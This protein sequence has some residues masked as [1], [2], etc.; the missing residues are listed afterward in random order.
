MIIFKRIEIIVRKYIPKFWT[1][2][3]IVR[4]D[5]IISIFK[6]GI[7]DNSIEDMTIGFWTKQRGL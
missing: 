3:D 2:W 4:K 7:L 6:N 1:R 5:G